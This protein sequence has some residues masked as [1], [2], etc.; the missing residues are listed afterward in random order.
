MS[1]PTPI[2]GFGLGETEMPPSISVNEDRLY[3]EFCDG[4]KQYLPI[5]EKILAKDIFSKIKE[6][7]GLPREQFEIPPSL[8]AKTVYDFAIAF[9]KEEVPKEETIKAFIPLYFGNTGSYVR[10]TKGMELR[11]VEDYLEEQSLIFED[12][13]T[14]L[15]ERW[16]EVKK[17]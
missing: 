16:N 1:K 4:F 3:T 13:K 15:T 7:S 6:I 10:V 9:H 12:T 5:Y 11:V 8:W 14:Y 2:F 17:A